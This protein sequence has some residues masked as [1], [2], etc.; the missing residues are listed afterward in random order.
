M[1][2]LVSI[3]IPAY[4][5]E[6]R[7]SYTLESVLNQDYKPVE[8]ILVNDASTDRT[9]EIAREILA[10]AS[11]EHL[12][13][14]HDGNKGECGTRNT[15]IKAA[16]GDFLLFWDADDL[17]DSDLVSNMYKAIGENQIAIGG[18]RSLEI[19]TGR[20]SKRRV[21]PNFAELHTE[22]LASMYITNKFSAS[23]C[24]CL[25]RAD[26]LNRIEL[27]FHPG[28]IAGGDVEFLTKALSRAESV[29]YSQTHS[30]I[31]VKHRNMGSLKDTDTPEKKLKRYISQTEARFRLAEYIQA[32][33]IHDR[34]K[35]IGQNL[36]LPEAYI[37]Q[38]NICVRQKDRAKFDD[39][40]R[41]REV[42]RA[43][44]NGLKSISLKPEIALK[45]ICLL[46]FPG[47]YYRLRS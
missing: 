37:R 38:L 36:I 24:S 34:L 5:A 20:V 45:S 35:W 22:T 16:K 41:S 8:L 23:V 30:Y 39:L 43:L 21:I 33:S 19:E 12:I 13:I 7:I 9:S 46:L 29:A 26:F 25:F 28:C 15:G 14:E 47:F 18:Y 44:S 1:G 11:I 10:S 40:L 27:E 17:G 4:N 31:Y 32:E 42:K 3:I 6:E 2:S